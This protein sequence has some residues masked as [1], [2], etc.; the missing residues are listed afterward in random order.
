MA[1]IGTFS[2]YGL[3][4]HGLL[5]LKNEYW[6]YPTPLLIEKI[7]QNDEGILSTRGAVIVNTG[8]FTGRS[9]NDKFIVQNEKSHDLIYWGKINQPINLDSFWQI[10]KKIITYLQQSEVYVQDMRAGSIQNG[11]IKI[12][13]ITDKAWASLFAFDLFIRQEKRD[14]LHHQPDFVVLH[15]PE[16]FVD[17][18]EDKTNSSTAIIIN[19]EKKE[20]LICGTMYAGEIKKAIFS[21]LNYLLPIQGILSMHCSANTGKS[22][23]V[24]L[25]FGL[26]GTG[27]TTLSSDPER[28][29]IGDDEHGWSDDGIFNI[30]GG[31]YAKTIRL[32]PDLEPLIWQ[33]VN[34]FGSVLENVDYDPL[35][36]EIDFDSEK[37]TE[38]TRGAYPLD[39]IPNHIPERKGGHPQNIFFLSADAFGVLPP[40]ARL[41]PEQAIYY[42]LSGY[43]SKLAGTEKGLGI[44]PQ[45]TFST[46]FGAPFLPLFPHIYANLLYE[47]ILKH[48][49]DVWLI[50]TGWTGGSYGIGQRIK[51]PITRSLIHAALHHHL[52]AVP[53]HDD[54]A[55]GFKVPDQCPSV[56][57]EFLHPRMT[58][59]DPSGYDQQAKTLISSFQKNIQQFIGNVSAEVIASGPGS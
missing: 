22:G 38:N 47:R 39:F 13:L 8:A 1:K 43:T 46:C 26:S 33:A 6:N 12:R 21:V 34:T 45:A 25:F 55:F 27:K 10:R 20:I 28:R 2:S 31:C 41:K 40:I 9:P 19:F 56:P 51:L 58:W 48:D 30:E 37:Y 15:C 44:K 57:A 35:T 29:L 54:P 11:N 32:K 53:W 16:L 23:D 3:E 52:D 17:S 42:F 5:N 18:S 14:L 50:N 59:N 7:I 36:H 49:T 24:A 4:N